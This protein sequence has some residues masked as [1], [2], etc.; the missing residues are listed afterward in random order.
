MELL[1]IRLFVDIIHRRRHTRLS[2]D[3][4][5][6]YRLSR[7]ATF[8]VKKIKPQGTQRVFAKYTKKKST[9]SNKSKK[10]KFRQKNESIHKKHQGISSG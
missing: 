6:I 3:F 4:N 1:F 9:A 7:I 2:H 8:V 10:S 5:K